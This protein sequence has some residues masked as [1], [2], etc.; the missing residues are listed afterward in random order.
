MPTGFALYNDIL[1]NAIN[2]GILVASLLKIN[3][4]PNR[5]IIANFKVKLN[6]GVVLRF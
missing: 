3:L 6:L 5:I 2:N 4:L 1:F